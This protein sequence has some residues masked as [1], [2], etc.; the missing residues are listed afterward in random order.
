MA[1][2]TILS[3][4]LAVVCAFLFGRSAIISCNRDSRNRKL[5]ET[6]QELRGR[7][8]LAADTVHIEQVFKIDEDTQNGAYAVSAKACVVL[9]NGEEFARFLKIKSFPFADDKEFA[10]RQAEELLDKLNEK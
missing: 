4:S 1:I 9:A 6:I 8:A 5:R 7:L 10:R 3:I 2:V